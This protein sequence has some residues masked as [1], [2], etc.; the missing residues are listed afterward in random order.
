MS[1]YDDYIEGVIDRRYIFVAALKRHI[2][3]DV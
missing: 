2:T 1:T 3:Q